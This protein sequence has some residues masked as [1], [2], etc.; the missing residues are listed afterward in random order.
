MYTP[1]L[2]ASPHVFY[3]LRRR[4]NILEKEVWIFMMLRKIY[5]LSYLT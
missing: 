5:P 2:K 3:V 1:E 4:I